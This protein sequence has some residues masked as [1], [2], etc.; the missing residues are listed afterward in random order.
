MRNPKKISLLIAAYSLP[1]AA[2]AV[3]PTGFGNWSASGGQIDAPC[4]DGFTCAPV[5]GDA[6]FLQRQMTDAQGVT[7]IQSILTDPNADGDPNNLPFASE[8]FVRM[9][10]G[11]AANSGIAT[12]QSITEA[13]TFDSTFEMTR[14]WA[15]P[16]G[17]SGTGQIRQTLADF[18]DPSIQTDDFSSGF[19]FD[20]MRRNDVGV[21]RRI[22]LDQTVGLNQG[23]TVEVN[24]WQSMAM[25][26]V[27]GEFQT[28]PGDATFPGVGSVNW[29]PGDPIMAGWVGQVFDETAPGRGGMGGTFGH[30][31]VMN[32]G[33][34]DAIVLDSFTQANPV[35][36]DELAFGAEPFIPEVTSP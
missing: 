34:G 15:A 30:N 11:G 25:T 10:G 4:P 5:V 17:A 9:G 6:G 18:G 13:D 29:S 20:G 24:D 19:A 21:G 33:T 31:A 8:D 35:D 7:F 23:G 32:M 14:G 28:T 3:P 1:F 36:W 22:E 27:M 16:E 12:R 2:L 26:I